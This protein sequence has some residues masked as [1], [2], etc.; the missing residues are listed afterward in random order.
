M[1]KPIRIVSKSRRI[2]QAYSLGQEA[3][4]TAELM[5]QYGVNNVRGAMF[6]ET[7]MYTLDDLAALTGFLGHHN[8][9]NYLEM[10]QMLRAELPP[11]PNTIHTENTDDTRKGTVYVLECQGNKFYVG[12]TK[13]RKQRL[14]EHFTGRGSKWTQM[15]KPIAIVQ[16]YHG[17]PLDYCLAKEAQVTAE[18]MLR[19]GVNNVRGAMFVETR[20]YSRSD[21]S[22]LTGFLGHFNNLNYKDI[23]KKLRMELTGT[24][25]RRKKRASRA[26]RKILSDQ[27]LPKENL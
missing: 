22:A 16:E 27:S 20:V 18:L 9:R 24:Q 3:Q 19:Y 26:R 25:K 11:A 14:K 2:P 17:I 1:H 21:L 5:L 8:S 6:G 7:R 10:E 23:E 15:H 12:C 13:F 4:V